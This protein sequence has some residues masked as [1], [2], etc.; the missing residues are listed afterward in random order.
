MEHIEDML[1]RY[2]ERR[3][4]A[5]YLYYDPVKQGLTAYP[6]REDEIAII[7]ETKIMVDGGVA[8]GGGQRGGGGAP[9]RTKREA[10][11]IGI[12][13]EFLSNATLVPITIEQKAA[14]RSVLMSPSMDHIDE[15]FMSK[16]IM[17]SPLERLARPTF[18]YPTDVDRDGWVDMVAQ[19]NPFRR[20]IMAI[21]RTL[22]T[23]T[24]GRTELVNP[25][26]PPA[27]EPYTG[28]VPRTACVPPPN[29]LP[30]S[31]WST[32][33]PRTSASR[34]APLPPPTSPGR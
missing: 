20:L 7:Q 29:H 4:A 30:I 19:V 11:S 31:S 16:Q 24:L 18:T 32:T 8:P 25:A 21:T 15:A 3:I 12:S 34:L 5:P 27:Y 14:I 28:E 9:R 26:S 6:G 13:V 22:A 2:T 1:Q 17:L 33:R 23:S 10:K